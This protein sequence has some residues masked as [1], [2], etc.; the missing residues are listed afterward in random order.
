LLRISQK[1]FDA[2]KAAYSEVLQAQLGVSQF[3][4]QR[5]LAD[6]R[7]DQATAALSQMIGEVP[8]KVEVID[9]DDNGIFKLSTERTE[10]VPAPERPLPSL[11][12]LLPVAYTQRRD[13][14]SAI[15]QTYSDRKSL[16]FAKSQRIPDLFV[17]SGYQ[18]STFR[19]NQPYGLFDGI[20]HNQPGC[21]LNITAGVPIFYRQEGE[22][23]QAKATWKQDFDEN[24]Q[25]RWQIASD[26]VTAYESVAVTRANIVKFQK[27]LIPAAAQV[28]AL[29]RR[30]YEVGK[31]D[32][33]NAILAKQQYQQI[34]SSYFDAV[35]NY[36]N[37]WA[38]LEKSIGVPLQL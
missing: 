9:V 27:Q 14:Q 4:T 32:L 28:A 37:A 6:A 31:T 17:D 1:R 34:L 29:A 13:L 18:F 33:A 36:Q 24:D 5:N 25:L 22:I 35:V 7:L 23:A 11:E 2:G 21:Y 3:D 38:D 19:P 15:Q 26:I 8:E 10:I 20:V 30:G 12:S 16:T